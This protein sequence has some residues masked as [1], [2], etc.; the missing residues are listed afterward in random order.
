M[1]IQK[2][3]SV[4]DNLY[5]QVFHIYFFAILSLLIVLITDNGNYNDPLNDN[6]QFLSRSWSI[7]NI[8]IFFSLLLIGII[9]AVGFLCIFQAYRIVPPPSVAPHLNTF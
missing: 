5:S 1:T 9:G 2:K 4:K 3:T 7:N 6:F 8:Y